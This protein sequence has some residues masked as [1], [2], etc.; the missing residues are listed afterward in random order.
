MNPPFRIEGENVCITMIAYFILTKSA[1]MDTTKNAPKKES[2]PI[3]PP[4]H[5]VYRSLRVLMG[6]FERADGSPANLLAVRGPQKE[7]W[8]AQAG[9]H[10]ANYRWP[11]L[12]GNFYEDI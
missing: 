10:Q 1:K 4:G 9:I 11:T 8:N 2:F 3:W 5:V 6:Q 12:R 7:R